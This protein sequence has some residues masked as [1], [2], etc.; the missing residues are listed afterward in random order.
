MYLIHAHLEPLPGGAVPGDAGARVVALT[1][2]EEGVRHVT[3]HAEAQPRPVLGLFVAA[4]SLTA[5][6][7]VARAL[8]ERAV[9]LDPGLAGIRVLR[10]EAPLIGPYYEGLVSPPTTNQPGWTH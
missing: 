5:A 8:C 7:T 3:L 9:E 2:P 10:C 6:E 4:S 1:R